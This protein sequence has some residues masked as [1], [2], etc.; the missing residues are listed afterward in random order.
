MARQAENQNRMLGFLAAGLYGAI[1]SSLLVSAFTRALS[2]YYA[3]SASRTGSEA[4]LATSLMYEPES[5]DAYETL[6]LIKQRRSDYLGAAAAFEKAAT[7]QANDYLLCLRLGYARQM[8]GDVEGAIEAFRRAIELAPHY[9]KPKY[10]LGML[11]LES[12]RTSDGFVFLSQAAESDPL[13]Y[14][15]IERLARKSFPDDADAIETA[16]RPTTAA[17]KSSLARYLIKYHFMTDSVRSFL[18]S[19]ALGTDEKNEFI[20]YLLHKKDF[21]LAREVWLSRRLQNDSSAAGP[22]YDGGFEHIDQSDPSGLGWQIGQNV[23]ATAVSR[24]LKAFHSGA[25][26]IRI[27]LA[28]NVELA[29]PIVS[30]LA[31]VEPRRLYALRFF[32]RSTE[33]ISAGP[34]EVSIVDKLT[35][36]TLARS[37][38][39]KATNGDWIP[40]SVEFV[41]GAS[42]VVLVSLQRPECGASPCPIF[43]DI[44]LD[45]IQLAEV[46]GK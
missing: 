16:V 26:S 45:D 27:K 5:S 21:E 22:I 24:D 2:L 44:S 18:L 25:S 11:L 36:E 23:S 35:N 12:G 33:M 28:G 38:P 39:I 4:E 43:G 30:Q 41:S 15:P 9:S 10:Y 46:V 40:V 6:G 1:L 19:D 14:R 3:D 8:N 29:R 42:P 32:Y 13:L 20:G 7:I 31:F 37:T 17:A 34:A